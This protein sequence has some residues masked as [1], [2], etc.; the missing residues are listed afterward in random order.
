ML[1]KTSIQY[2]ETPILPSPW[3]GEGD[4]GLR[5]NDD[6]ENIQTFIKLYSGINFTAILN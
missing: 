4:T 6:S 5:Q 3:K 1:V 2:N